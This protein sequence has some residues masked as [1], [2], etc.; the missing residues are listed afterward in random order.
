MDATYANDVRGL[1]KATA[2]RF[3]R[4]KLYCT[5]VQ[6]QDVEQVSWQY[7]LTKCVPPQFIPTQVRWHLERVFLGRANN[8][9]QNYLQNQAFEYFDSH[10][11]PHWSNSV[12]DDQY[13]RLLENLWVI[14]NPRQLSNYARIAVR[15]QHHT[16]NWGAR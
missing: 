9:W 5:A 1:V 3:W 7:L 2:N 12:S 16:T 14:G 10:A 11:V 8:G 4:Q 15:R 13:A 6:V